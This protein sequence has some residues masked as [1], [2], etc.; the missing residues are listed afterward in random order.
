MRYHAVVIVRHFYHYN[1]V[2][3]NQCESSCELFD[4]ITTEIY[5][6]RC[7]IKI[8]KNDTKKLQMFFRLVFFKYLMLSDLLFP[9]KIIFSFGEI[10]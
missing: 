2:T 7:T 3:D 10:R 1:E 5:N 9:S 6:N 4:I 8:Y